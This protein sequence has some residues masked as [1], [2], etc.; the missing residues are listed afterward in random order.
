MPS[1][2]ENKPAAGIE[3]YGGY[4]VYDEN[5]ID[6]TTLRRNLTLSLENRLENNA[7]AAAFFAVLR[8]SSHAQERPMPAPTPRPFI[9]DIATL[10]RVLQQHEVEFVVIGGVAM[11]AHGSNHV[12]ADMDVCYNRSPSNLA[13]VAAA[14]TSI[15]AYLRGVPKG[16]PFKTDV[17]TL[18]AGLNFT[19][20]TDSGDLDLL[21][22]VSGVGDYAQALARSQEREIYGR[23]VA[24]LSLD[25]LI[26]AKKAA[27]RNKDHGHLLELEALKKLRDAGPLGA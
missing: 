16:L 26:A 11:I 13:A 19:L 15:H 22:E 14:L 3:F 1:H 7:R 9:L 10:L 25:D 8:A 6:L 4:Q 12:T 5:G 23:K 21:G 27:G 2:D 20:E 18:Q 24:V 17:P